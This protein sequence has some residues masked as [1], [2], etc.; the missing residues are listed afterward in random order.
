MH[1][2][3][4]AARR[5]AHDGLYRLGV[6]LKVLFHLCEHCDARIHAARVDLEL[7]GAL[8]RVRKRVLTAFELHAAAVKHVRVGALL[9]REGGKLLPQLSHARL[10]VVDALLYL[11][12]AA[13]LLGKLAQGALA[14]FNAAF[15]IR[16]YSCK[17]RLALGRR[18]LACRK[19]LA[20][21]LALHIF[22]MHALKDAVGGGVKRLKLVSGALK[23][24]FDLIILG[25]DRL[26]VGAEL[27]QRRH[28]H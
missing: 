9:L 8:C 10:G 27:I 17:P 21:T 3:Q 11:A 23:L 20:R 26:G 14:A 6:A 24:A 15:N 4:I 16:L 5:F 7:C 28:P 18:R 25:V 12:D 19:A 2:A 1:A 13:L 22:L